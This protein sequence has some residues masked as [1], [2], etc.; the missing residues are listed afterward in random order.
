M[1][2]YIRKLRHKKHLDLYLRDIRW[3]IVNL[4]IA[5]SSVD[6]MTDAQARKLLNLG[7]LVRKYER[8]RKLIQF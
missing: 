3:E 6:I 4:T 7:G 8:R 5:A 1:K 2:D